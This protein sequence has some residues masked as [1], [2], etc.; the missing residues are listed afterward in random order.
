MAETQKKNRVIK[1]PRKSAKVSDFVQVALEGSKYVNVTDN[2][3][4]R[5]RIIKDSRQERNY[6][7]LIKYN[8]T[9]FLEIKEL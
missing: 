1:T 3:K 2:R 7:S 6:G 8:L 4:H 5:K 9:A